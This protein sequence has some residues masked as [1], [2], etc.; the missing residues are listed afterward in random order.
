MLELLLLFVHAWWHFFV[1]GLYK[2]HL[3]SICS[4]TALLLICCELSDSVDTAECIPL[5]L[6]PYRCSL[7][8]KKNIGENI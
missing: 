5:Y 4:L 6:T 7:V 2:I 8:Q 1:K 3:L